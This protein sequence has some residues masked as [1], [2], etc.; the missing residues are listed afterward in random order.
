MKKNLV[1]LI[2]FSVIALLAAAC[3]G[4]F[5]LNQPRLVWIVEDHYIGAWEQALGDYP[6]LAG[7]IV[8]SSE[9]KDPLP[10]SWYGYRAGSSQNPLGDDENPLLVYLGLA[11]QRHYEDALLLALD[12]WLVFRRFTSPSLSREDAENGPG[13]RGRLLIAGGDPAAAWAWTA[14]LL[15]ESPGVFSHGPGRWEQ[16][17]EWLFTSG[18][19]QT[20]ARTFGWEEIWPHLLD[21]DEVVWVYAPL[22][23]L[24]ALPLV[25][26]NT[27]E[28]DVFPVRPG[29]NQF[30]LQARLFWATP[31]G[32][33]KNR[34]RLEAA[35]ALLQ[36]APFQNLLA[37]SLGWIAA[38]PEAPPFNPFS[39]NA[40]IS[41]LTSSYIWSER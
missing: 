34:E 6:A 15:Q 37:D 21:E 24:R 35:E 13:E 28:A 16:A 25:D 10:R 8:P 32:S 22:S 1:F 36:G 39:W 23:R 2:V 5:F 11:G 38:H 14:Q 29:W 26:T 31:Y 41:W 4:L 20:G 18:Q 9:A 7:R 33:E 40:R 19:F 27:L 30:G 3:L 17:Q 12:P